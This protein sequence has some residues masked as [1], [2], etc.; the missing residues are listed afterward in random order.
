M[1][2]LLNR[3]QI[4]AAIAV[5]DTTDNHP[6]TVIYDMAE[7][8]GGDL[9]FG[10]QNGVYRLRNN[11]WQHLTANQ[12]TRRSYQ[13]HP[14]ALDSKD[15]LWFGDVNSGLIL[16]ENET[17]RDLTKA[18]NILAGW[19]VERLEPLANGVMRV[20]MYQSTAFGNLRKAF[21]CNGRSVSA[22]E[23]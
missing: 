4:R 12:Q 13:A 14:I 8:D 9:Y 2:A 23:K 7:S 18:H 17:F 11:D 10:T 16:H 21:D 5:A 22:V 3:I 6:M 19:R 1:T 15:R 20:H